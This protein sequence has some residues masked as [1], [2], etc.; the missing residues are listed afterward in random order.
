MPFTEESPFGAAAD[1]FGGYAAGQQIAQNQALERQR[2]AAEIAA[3]QA[4]LKH[5]QIQDNI[6]QG[7]NPTTGQPFVSTIPQ[8]GKG[9][10]DAQWADWARQT[11][12]A[13][14]KSGNLGIAKSYNDLAT[15]YD[16]G[17]FRESEAQLNIQGNLPLRRSESRLDDAKTVNVQHQF[18][19]D[20]DMITARGV[21][22]QSVARIRAAYRAAGGGRRGGAGSA[23]IESR[24]LDAALN[25]ASREGVNAQNAL[26]NSI[27]RYQAD[28][29]AKDPTDNPQ[30]QQPQMIPIPVYGG[31]GTTMIYVNPNGQV[32]RGQ[33][34][35][36]PS[37][38]RASGGG[39]ARPSI[40]VEIAAAK[41]AGI[42][43]LNTIRQALIGAGYPAAQVDAALFPGGGFS[44]P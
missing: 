36:A 42:H 25:A 18:A 10:T 6:D 26:A 16:T 5:Q 23:E 17:A 24:A 22:A 32:Q 31:G 4:S 27:Y 44:K 8:P 38:S 9:A 35:L 20:L 21:S 14:M 3:Q 30:P 43:D 39:G 11:S 37:A 33:S 29:Y 40:Q 28:L 15:G 13:A 1:A 34:N 19:H 41:K 12:A 7:L 2:L